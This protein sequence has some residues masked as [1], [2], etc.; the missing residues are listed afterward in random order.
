M[1][2]GGSQIVRRHR[3]KQNNGVDVR[4]ISFHD[5]S[6]VVREQMLPRSEAV[7]DTNIDGEEE[8]DANDER[9]NLLV[10]GR[11]IMTNLQSP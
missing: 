5:R 4:E 2:G 6:G 10:H 9:I 11:G 8:R 7:Q 3:S 1:T